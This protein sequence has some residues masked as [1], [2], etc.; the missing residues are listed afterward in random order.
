MSVTPFGVLLRWAARRGW[1]RG[2][3]IGLAGLALPAALLLAA[4][5]EGLLR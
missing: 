5:V 2:T 3:V 4:L 1:R